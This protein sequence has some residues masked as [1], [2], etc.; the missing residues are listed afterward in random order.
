MPVKQLELAELLKRCRSTKEVEEINSLVESRRKLEE[1]ARVTEHELETSRLFEN[2]KVD[3][4]RL[5]TS[6]LA[7][8]AFITDE[9]GAGALRQ[10]ISQKGIKSEIIEGTKGKK[11]ILF[12]AFDTSQR[13]RMDEVVAKRLRLDE[14]DITEGYL[15]APP[16]EVIA[17]LEKESVEELRELKLAEQRLTQIGETH[18]IE[19]ASLAE[20]LEA[21]YERAQI[22]TNFKNTA[23][24][25]VVEG[26]IPKKSLR[27][28]DRRIKEA[29]KQSF[30]VEEVN[31]GEIAPTMM[32]RGKTFSEFDYLMG[33]YSLPMSN[34]IDPTW[35][36]IVSFMVFYGM[37]V[38]DFG[39]GVMSLILATLLVKKFPEEGLMNSVARVWQLASIPIMAFG[40]ISNQFFGLSLAPFK[41]VMFIDWNNNVP[42]LLVLTV[43]MGI[44]QVIVGLAIGFVNK[45]MHHERKLAVS[46]LTSIVA[47]ITGTLAVAGAFFGFMSSYAV[48]S[49]AIAS[50]A[51]II[52]IALSGIEAVEFTN[53]ISH[54][55]SYTRIFGFGLASMILAS[56]I[57]KAFTP[58]LSGGIIP[59]I[60][61]AAMFLL[62]HT[63]NMILSIFEGMVQATRLNFIEFFSKFYTGG[64]VK[65]APYR[66]NRTIH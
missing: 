8:R 26:W 1:R 46:K 11:L 5:T 52:T 41:G 44:A 33:F 48:I 19:I 2:M 7:F 16:K 42:G 39:Y 58:T 23:R 34:E 28:L 65:F 53:L 45:Y 31:D 3:F 60:L 32:S 22:S 17:R 14:I 66:F 55:L 62:L 36:F 37:M 59:F 15:N 61:L 30:I 18:Y 43:I 63:M 24:T 51:S 50:A 25:F 56:L 12:V 21:E 4:G 38:S 13:S 27:E 47:V 29:T 49:A 57:D 64:G 6:A 54:P 10:Q 40:I 9:K 35:F 20:M